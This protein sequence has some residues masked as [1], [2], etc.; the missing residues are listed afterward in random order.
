MNRLVLGTLAAIT[1]LL[2]LTNDEAQAQYF[3]RGFYRPVVRP[4]YPAVRRPYFPPNR[5]PGWDWEYTYPYSPYNLA[6]RYAYPYPVPYP[7]YTSAPTTTV[8]GYN[9]NPAYVPQPQDV[10]VPQATGPLKT[11]PPN[12][13]LIVVRVPAE[14]TDVYF[15]GVRA[16]SVGLTRYYAT[17]ELPPGQPYKYAITAV[18]NRN[19][20]PVRVE[21][22]ISVIAGQTTVVDFTRPAGS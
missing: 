17:P 19:G 5:M 10:L 6:R 15:D 3:R 8:A 18:V 21:R 12:S 11:P 2:G 13:A 16:T 20:Q 7:V 9:S 14:F 1:V 22:D 4:Y